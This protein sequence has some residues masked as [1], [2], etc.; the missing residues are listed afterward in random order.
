MQAHYGEQ[1]H[2]SRLWFGYVCIFICMCICADICIYIY[3][4]SQG[5]QLRAASGMPMLNSGGRTF[6]AIPKLQGLCF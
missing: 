5:A 3:I 1:G 4:V 6:D 2:G